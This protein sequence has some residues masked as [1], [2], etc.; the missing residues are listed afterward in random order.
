[1]PIMTV[2]SVDAAVAPT[3]YKRRCWCGTTISNSNLNDVC[4]RHIGVAPP[5]AFRKDVTSATATTSAAPAIPT[6]SAARPNPNPQPNIAL[7]TKVLKGKK[8]SVN[9]LRRKDNTMQ[10]VNA[11]SFFYGVDAKAIMAGERHEPIKAARHVAIYIIRKYVEG[12][13]LP[14][15]GRFFKN[16]HTTIMYG[17]GQV[18]ECLA[19]DDGDAKKI[20]MERAIE[21]IRKL[22]LR[23]RGDKLVPF[24]NGLDEARE[25]LEII[26]ELWEL[27]AEQLLQPGSTRPI[28]YVRGIAEFILHE[29]RGFSFPQLRSLF[30]EALS[31]TDAMRRYRETARAISY[32]PQLR[33]DVERARAALLAK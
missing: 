17:Q 29:T 27:T 13:S 2:G 25:V 24:N 26:G 8:K 28:P 18:Q 4:R 5:T 30:H 22:S 12:A 19:R 9:P 10:I 20:Q 16:H 14:W 1:M 6:Q 32:D 33:E 11:T 31:P 21:A 23:M 15:I 7:A 3:D